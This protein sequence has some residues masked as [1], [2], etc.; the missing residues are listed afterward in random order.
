MVEKNIKEQWQVIW[1]KKYFK[2]KEHKWLHVQDGFDELNYAQ[3]EGMCSFFLNKIDIKNTDD[4]LEVGCGSGAF[5]KQ[6]KAYKSISG[7]DYSTDAIENIKKHIPDGKFYYTEANKLPFQKDSFDK[8]ICFS[9]FFYFVSYE[10]ATQSLE[11]MLRVLRQG[12]EIFIGEVSD[13]NKKDIAIKLRGDS[14][15]ARKSRALDSSNVEHLYYS[16]DFFQKFAEKNNLDIELI[17]EDVPELSF[18][19]SA[20]YRFSILLRRLD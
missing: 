20:S 11:E 16:T 6:I 4:V 19:E 10:Y 15:K 2:Y 5:S 17:S 18:Y 9:V 7:I 12:G 8:I 14:E 1:D 3:W 13:I